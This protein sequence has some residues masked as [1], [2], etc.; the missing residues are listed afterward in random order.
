MPH[1]APV[2]RDHRL[3]HRAPTI[4]TMHIARPQCASLDVAEL[5]E[6]EQ[7]VVTGTAKVAIIGA[8]FLFAMGGT[9]ARIHVEY[10]DLR[11]S[12]PA[13]FVNPLTGQI[14][15][16]R[17]VLGPAQPLCLKAAHLAGRSGKP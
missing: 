12:P 13:H 3:Q 15:E 4:G 14:S 16:S 8:A 6:H 7:R 2:T 5:I 10:D 11:P 1:D 9:L 17:K